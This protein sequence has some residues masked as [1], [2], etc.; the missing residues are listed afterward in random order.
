MKIHGDV[1]LL[2]DAYLGVRRVNVAVAAAPVVVDT[3]FTTAGST[4]VA[5][6]G[7]Y[8]LAASRVGTASR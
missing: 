5:G 3:L 6:V 1:V 4:A 8:V 7:P 2:A